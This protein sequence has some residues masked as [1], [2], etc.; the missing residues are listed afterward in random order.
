VWRACGV[1]SSPL[2]RDR[3]R[4]LG[5]APAELDALIAPVPALVVQTVDGATCRLAYGRRGGACGVDRVRLDAALLERAASS[6]A[7]V[8]RG[9]T[10]KAVRPGEGGSSRIEVSRNGEAEEWTARLVVGADGPGSMVARAFGVQLRA[11]RLR[12]AGLTF[13]LDVSDAVQGERDARMIIGRGWYCGVCPV[14][15]GRVNIGIVIG[16]GQLRRALAGGERPM[17]VARRILGELPE[18]WN[19]LADRAATDEIA[20]ALPLANRVSRR[21]GPGFLLVGDATGFIDPISGEGVHRALV[22]AEL[23]AAAAVSA[24]A[25]DGSAALADYDRYLRAQF[26]RKDLISW[27]L[28]AFLARSEVLDYAVRR[29][30][31]RSRSRATFADVMA[32]LAPPERALHP[33]FLAGVL[34]P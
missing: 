25:D 14:P 5:F 12:R 15:G 33:R 32:D 1:Y 11:Q 7:R 2:T 16:E 34:W 31:S 6:G 19:A 21:A 8:F 27:L 24:L 10:V 22:S 28:Q 9:A 23:G 17:G 4:A 29:L 13:H 18:P 26:G 30:G 20:V 3:L